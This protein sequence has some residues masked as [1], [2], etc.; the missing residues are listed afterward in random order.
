MLTQSGLLD[1][2]YL[3]C[4]VTPVGSLLVGRKVKWPNTGRDFSRD[5][6]AVITTMFYAAAADYSLGNQKVQI[7]EQHF[8][9][10]S[11]F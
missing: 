7:H 9:K 5:F 8:T 2:M 11:E 10:L 4:L 6:P 3:F 1:V